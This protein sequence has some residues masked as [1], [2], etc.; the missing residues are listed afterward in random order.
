MTS[1]MLD[2]SPGFFYIVSTSD[3]LRTQRHFNPMDR[4]R[5][6][7]FLIPLVTA[8]SDAFAI[9]AAFL[10]SYWLRFHSP[11]AGVV[12][13][14]LGVPPLSAYVYGSFFVIPIWLLMFRS[15]KLYGAHRNV[16]ISDEFFA[17]VRVVTMGMLV[18]MSAAF[19]YRA[20]SYSRV[21]FGFIFVASLVFITL[22]RC[23]II[24]AEKF[25]Y[26]R[27]KELKNV[28]LLGSNLVARMVYQKVVKY[29]TLGYR[30]VGYFAESPV[31]FDNA[32]YLG[33]VHD[34]HSRIKELDIELLL[35][36]LS[37]KEYPLLYEMIEDCAGINV[38]FMMVP[39]MLELMTSRVRIREIEGTPFIQIKDIALTTWDCIVKRIFDI[40]FSFFIL[41]FTFPF[42]VLIIVLIRLDSRGPVFYLQERVGLDGKRFNCIKFRSMNPEAEKDSGPVY[43]QEND[44]RVT[45]MGRLLRRTGIDELPQFIN[46]LKGNMS[47][48]GPRPERPF[49]IEKFRERIPKYLD[50]HRMK[51]GITG[52]AQVNGLRG[53]TPIDE[54]TKYDIYY[55]E[56]W[57][58]AFDLKI[59]LKTIKAMLVNKQ[60]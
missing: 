24:E 20:F 21:V 34:I 27:G 9:E 50:R 48:V 46:V 45:P 15:R 1:A 35:I 28:A 19:F 38:E 12:E 7:D 57:S 59:I 37:Y 47:V 31:E 56:N 51:A 18:V 22:G 5:R 43:A 25:L 58:L 29:P 55:V 39:D 40:L 2:K 36:A 4:P 14:A 33:R 30:F 16:Y 32:S 44:P 42:A 8:M 53:N 23:L 17:V 6:N 10:A 49:F 54:R 52:W 13:V 11:F 60:S 41:I 26:R 3:A